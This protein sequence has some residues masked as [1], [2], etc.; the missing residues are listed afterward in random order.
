MAVVTNMTKNVLYNGDCLEVMRNHIGENTVDIVL[1]SPFY[2]TARKTQTEAAFEYLNRR[3][4]VHLDNMTDDEYIQFTVDLFT[5]YD[6][7]LKENGV[8]LYNIS[9]STEKPFLMHLVIADIM[10]NTDFVVADTIAW[11]KK[12]ALP[13]NMNSNR[14]TRIVEFVYVF[15]RKDELKT[16][17][18]NKAVVSVREKT[19]QKNYENIFNF[20]EAKNNDGTCKLNKATYSTELCD[21]LLSMYAHDRAVVYDSFNGTGTTAVSAINLGLGYI[22]SEISEEQ[23]KYTKERVIKH[24]CEDIEIVRVES[25]KKLNTASSE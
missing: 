22:G 7:V 8:V 17:N 23:C 15:C 16:F 19:G 14:L 13:N 4:D 10:R 2:N 24:T 9:Y 20:I 25:A 1:T 12:S 18:A 21:K 5:G 6:K 3:Y 11:K